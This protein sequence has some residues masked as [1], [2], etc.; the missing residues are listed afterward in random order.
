MHPL[1]Q[2]GAQD[3]HFLGCSLEAP[4][5][6]ERSFGIASVTWVTCDAAQ[7]RLALCDHDRQR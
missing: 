5:W 3:Q 1:T 2:R 4:P 7:F 6:G